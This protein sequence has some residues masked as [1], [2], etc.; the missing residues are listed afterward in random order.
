MLGT[1]VKLVVIAAVILL[2]GTAVF[3]PATL[4][5]VDSK[6]LA[7]SLGGEVA[8][9][10]ADCKSDGSGFWQCKLS[11]G[12]LSGSEYALTTHRFGC[13]TGTRLGRTKAA[14]AAYRSVSGCIGLTDLFG[15]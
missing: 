9:S 10:H 1:V 8:H 13:W 3:R 12:N 5:G 7:N 14:D 15:H 6:A 2:V 4:F 11:G